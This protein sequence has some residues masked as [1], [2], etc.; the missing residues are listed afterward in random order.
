MVKTSEKFTLVNS[1]GG[2]IKRFKSDEKQCKAYGKCFL[3]VFSV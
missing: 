1:G 2:K 3:S